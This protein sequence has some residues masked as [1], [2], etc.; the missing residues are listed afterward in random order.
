MISRWSATLRTWVTIAP[1]VAVAT[2]ALSGCSAG[3]I[4][5]TANHVAAINGSSVDVGDISLRNVYLIPATAAGTCI[6]QQNGSARLSFTAVNNSSFRPDRL[7]G[8]ESDAA[9]SVDINAPAA[10]LTLQ[11]K[12]ALAA[13]Q[14]IE[15]VKGATAPDAPIEVVVNNPNEFTRPG[16]TVPLTFRFEKAG[17]ATVEVPL[18]ACPTPP[19][20]PSAGA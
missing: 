2:I 19:P 5:Q 18:D 7:I 20:L 1:V 16:L 13:G 9:T 14:P 15:Q 4:S 6:E 3:Q 12:T 10:A 11:P 17:A 8:I